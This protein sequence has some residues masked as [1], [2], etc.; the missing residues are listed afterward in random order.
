MSARFVLLFLLG[1][2]YVL[3]FDLWWWQEPSRFL[4]LPIGLSYHVLFC[5]VVSGL[6]YLLVTYAWPSGLDEDEEDAG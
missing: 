5:V 4:G 3:R 1:L 2:L 6:F